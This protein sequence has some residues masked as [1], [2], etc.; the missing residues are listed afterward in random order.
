MEKSVHRYH[1]LSSLCMPRNAKHGNPWDRCFY[2]TPT[3][4]IDSYIQLN[5]RFFILYICVGDF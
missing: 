3:L 4:V 2:P 5:T 1:R